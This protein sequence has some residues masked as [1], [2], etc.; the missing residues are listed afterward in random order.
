MSVLRQ[1]PPL[2]S[3]SYPCL[4]RVP[5][6]TRRVLLD[7]GLTA[8][9]VAVGLLSGDGLTLLSPPEPGKVVKFFGSVQEW[10]DQLLWWWLA[11]TPTVA[12][13]FIRHRRP[14]TAMGLAALGTLGHA[15]VPEMPHLSFDLVNLLTIHT[16]AAT[17]RTRRGSVAALVAVL[18][19]LCLLDLLILA[20]HFGKYTLVGPDVSGG[21]APDP[22]VQGVSQFL[23]PALLLGISWATGDNTRTRRAHL[24]TLEARATDLRREQEQRTALAVAAER[25]RITRE[26]HDVVAHGLS[27]MV[28]QAQGAQAAL[29]RHPE[30]SEAA[31]TDVISTGRASLAE[32]RRLL[33]LVRAEPG[34]ELTPQPGLATL[35]E[36]IEQVR[37]GGTPVAFHVTG[38]PAALPAG[39]ELSAY[40]II[41]EAL[42][43]I[44]K[45]AGPGSDCTVDLGFAADRLRI[46]VRN[47]GARVPVPV[48]GNGLRG[49]AERVTA[50][51]GTLHAGPGHEG[52]F[53]VSTV[54]P[55]EAAA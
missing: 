33:G 37:A 15:R 47:S 51:G 21:K 10:K 14:L 39:V 1:M 6:G 28:I 12:A 26:L 41:Q 42:T 17:A 20:G 23:I 34:A 44:L 5:A 54:L 27:V 22:M 32:M 31:L 43:N 35:P 25:G 29:H 48:F 52:G 46:R 53:E 8:A 7:I 50:L 16:L 9:V 4:M 13:V 3:G 11:T 40:R 49:I 36:L 38:E 30:R 45:H 24:A 55:L 18:V 2:L 19:S